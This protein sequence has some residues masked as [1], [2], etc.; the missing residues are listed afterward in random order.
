MRTHKQ[1]TCPPDAMPPVIERDDIVLLW[2]L[3]LM[4]PLGGHKFQLRE[5]DFRDDPLAEALGFGRYLCGEQSARY[6]LAEVRNELFAIWKTAEE[7]K[8]SF[9]QK[10]CELRANVDALCTM[11]GL[12]N[13]EADILHFSVMARING[14]LETGVCLHGTQTA[15]SLEKLFSI[16]LDLPRHE[17]RKALL[18]TGTLSMSGL[19]WLDMGGTYDF[20]GKVELLKGLVDELH[21]HHDDPGNI[22]RNIIYPSHSPKL[23][24][25]NFPQL[26]H[27]VDLLTDYLATSAIDGRKGINVLLHGVPGSGKTEFVRM[28]AK[29]CGLDLYEV[30]SGNRLDAPLDAELRFRAYRLGQTLCERRPRAAIL[31]DEV[32]DVF[33]EP[34]SSQVQEGNSSGKKGWINHILEE[35]PVPAFW[36]TNSIEIMDGAYLRRFDFVLELNAPPR[37]VR[38]KVLS[39]YLAELPV[40]ATWKRLMADHEALVPAVVERAAKVVTNMKQPLSQAAAERALEQ[41]MGNTVEAMGYRRP[42]KPATKLATCYRLENLNVDQDVEMLC[43]GLAQH[44]QGRICLFGPPGTGKTAFGRY[45]AEILDL[46]L[47]AKRASDII[48]PYVGMT[49]RNMAK[50]FRQA[51]EENAVLMLDEADTFLQDRKNAHQSWEI[52]AVNEM[53]TQMD[54]YEGVFIASTNFMSSLDAASLRRF[55]IKLKFDYLRPGQAWAMFLDL[56]QQQGVT[57]CESVKPRLQRLHAITPGDFAAVSRKLRL[58]KAN[59]PD[60]LANMIESECLVKPD[61]TKRAIGF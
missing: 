30:A 58:V 32:E 7:H 28:L 12:S 16:C 3:R 13:T 33:C 54:S 47:L 11:L 44:R 6:D 40:S 56:A 27:E 36:V 1:S 35:N 20:S 34:Q 15:N 38:E 18:P 45:V 29:R 52:S 51:R 24:E 19:L 31:F 14:F 59:T 26:K 23:Q 39:E 53:L 49:E 48:A 8:C 60:T 4:V 21:I 55:D 37:S 17:V 9:Q 5:K 41:I 10:D 61:C 46:P 2:L 42:N 50:M 22:L 25:S 57:A 43:N